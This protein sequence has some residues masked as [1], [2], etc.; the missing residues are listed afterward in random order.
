MKDVQLKVEVIKTYRG[1]SKDKKIEIA[2]EII[3]SQ[4]ICFKTK[5]EEDIDELERLIDLFNNGTVAVIKATYFDENDVILDRG[6]CTL[7]I[8]DYLMSTG[9]KRQ[10]WLNELCRAT[11]VKPKQSKSPIKN[12]IQ[13]AEEFVRNDYLKRRTYQLENKLNLL[14]EKNPEHGNAKGLLSLY[15]NNYGFTNQGDVPIHPEDYYYMTKDL[16]Q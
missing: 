2:L 3:E 10:Y 7:H 1:L 8:D 9:K 6:I 4:K 15:T 12:V 14:V 11:F 16:S 13:I 5:D